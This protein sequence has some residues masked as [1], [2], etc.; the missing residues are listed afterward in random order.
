MGAKQPPSHTMHLHMPHSG[1]QPWGQPIDDPAESRSWD[2]AA[3]LSFLPAPAASWAELL[4]SCFPS[5]AADLVACKRIKLNL[6]RTI[7]G[8]WEAK[9]SLPDLLNLSRTIEGFWEAKDSLPDLL[10]LSRTI[11]G[12]WE[13]KDSLLEDLQ[14]Q[15]SAKEGGKEVKELVEQCCSA[16]EGGKVGI[17]LTRQVRGRYLVLHLVRKCSMA[18]AKQGKHTVPGHLFIPGCL[19]AQEAHLLSQ[20]ACSYRTNSAPLVTTKPLRALTGPGSK[21]SSPVIRCV[22]HCVGAC[23]PEAAAAT[24]EAPVAGNGGQGPFLAAGALAAGPRCA[25]HRLVRA[26]RH[27][28]GVSMGHRGQG[29]QSMGSCVLSAMKL[30]MVVDKQLVGAR[31]SASGQSL[32]RKKRRALLRARPVVVFLVVL[33]LKNWRPRNLA[34]LLGYGWHLLGTAYAYW[35]LS[36]YVFTSSG[37]SVCVKVKPNKGSM[38]IVNQEGAKHSVWCLCPTY[39]IVKMISTLIGNYASFVVHLVVPVGLCFLSSLCYNFEGNMT[40]KQIRK[41]TGSHYVGLM[42]LVLV[43]AH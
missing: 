3:F 21:A 10:N 37:P 25:V 33:F 28:A 11:E 34:G 43:P 31:F 9:D 8:F 12:F 39:P 41:R 26:V 36:V 17:E 1:G 22:D 42:G 18:V 38:Q 15:R 27:E 4:I 7:E 2:P 14:A 32:S 16:G 6:S 30:V 23:L 40:D 35:A 13:A 5:F 29:V 20:L 24:G 19:F